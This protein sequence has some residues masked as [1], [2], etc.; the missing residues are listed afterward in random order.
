MGLQWLSLRSPR[1]SG[2]ASIFQ[3]GHYQAKRNPI[4]IHLKKGSGQTLNFTLTG[5]GTLLV[6]EV[7]QGLLPWQREGNLFGFLKKNKENGEADP[8]ASTLNWE[9]YCLLFWL[10]VKY[11]NT[12]R[13]TK[14]RGDNWSFPQAAIQET[15]LWPGWATPG[16]VCLLIRKKRLPLTPQFL[17]TFPFFWFACGQEGH[18]V[19]NSKAAEPLL[20]PAPAEASQVKAAHRPGVGD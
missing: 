7:E 2:S 1:S 5:A 8:L 12:D 3:G 11:T 16:T 17:P 14:Y 18:S 15:F 9:L 19:P 10:H 20:P 13:L 4:S 6:A